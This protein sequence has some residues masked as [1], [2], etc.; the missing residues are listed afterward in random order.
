MVF[1]PVGN[2]R[3]IGAANSIVSSLQGSL[4]AFTAGTFKP[5][6]YRGYYR[7]RDNS[8]WDLDRIS[9]AF[10]D[11]SFEA[12]D[13]THFVNSLR[14]LTMRRYRENRCEQ[15]SVWV[16]VMPLANDPTN[17]APVIPLV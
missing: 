16:T 2:A 4:P 11:T 3:E 9:V 13:L 8:Q 10:V 1:L 12:G 14:E 6:P 17:N 15:E 7:R 5:A